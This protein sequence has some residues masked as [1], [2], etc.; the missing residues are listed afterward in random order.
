MNDKKTHPLAISTET[1]K[2]LLD[3]QYMI[4]LRGPR[5]FL[6]ECVEE[7]INDWFKK[8]TDNEKE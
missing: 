5:K 3:A 4:G 2:K 6:R 7:A 1:Y 8:V